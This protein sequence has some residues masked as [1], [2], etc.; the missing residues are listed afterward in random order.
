MDIKANTKYSI[1]LII[2]FLVLTAS[3]L[4]HLSVNDVL[5]DQVSDDRRLAEKFAPILV[6]TENPTPA[7][8]SYA[9]I[10]PE[11]V[12][13]VGADSV[14]NLWFTV[15]DLLGSRISSHLLSDDWHPNPRSDIEA[16]CPN[17]NFS[18]NLFAFAHSYPAC[19]TS[20]AGVTPSGDGL[21]G[22]VRPHHFDYPG[23][24]AA[25]WYAAYFPRE[26]EDDTYAGWKFPNTVYF[27]VFN[28][29]SS[30]NYG[31]VVIKYYC[32]YP[33][34]DW[35]NNHEGDW[36]KINVMVTSRDPD[37]A[38]I[39]GVDYTF[40]G[41]GIT[42]YNITNHPSK[43]SIRQTIAP[44]GGRYPVVYVSAGGHGHFPTPGHYEDGGRVFVDEDLTPYG[45]VLHPE[46]V[47]SNRNK[48]IAQSYDLVL[49]PEPVPSNDDNMGLDPEMS[50]LGAN[51][52]WGTPKVFSWPFSDNDAPQGP[53]YSSWNRIR[54]D[55][56][57]SKRTDYPKSDIP[58]ATF[59]NFPIVGD[60]TWGGT[61]SLLGD[62][63]VFPRATLTIQP[64][65]V[66]EFAPGRDQ[67]QFSAP[68][69]DVAT[70]LPEISVVVGGLWLGWY[71]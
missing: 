20:W 21:T 36:T 71:S 26:G 66:I 29:D 43:H 57:S 33:F 23:N 27:H 44:V 54:Y 28:R 53:F 40:H 35:E 52:L 63:V 48:D 24:G 13:I 56:S 67:H 9:V 17:I 60:V 47:D 31:S 19:R 46:I 11:P 1:R 5:A 59:H 14:S 16:N 18:K 50:W 41:K 3:I 38:E 39:H 32:F 70:P 69:V 58:Y 15:E 65:T 37:E 64:G 30:D 6:L 22:F 34:N 12:E 4:L 7:G 8:R 61:V 2:V 68:S 25:S 51:V 10:H 42:Y 45:V 62:I 49:L 55:N